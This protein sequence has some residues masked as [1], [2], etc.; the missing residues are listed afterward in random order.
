MYLNSR[1][2]TFYNDQPIRKKLVL[3]ERM[4]AILSER[5]KEF[6]NP[7]I[8]SNR[9]ES[10]RNFRRENENFYLN[11]IK[12]QE[13]RIINLE[14]QVNNKYQNSDKESYLNFLE[15]RIKELNDDLHFYY[16]K[17]IGL[18]NEVINLFQN[19]KVCGRVNAIKN[20]EFCLNRLKIVLSNETNFLT[21][22]ALRNEA[23]HNEITSLSRKIDEKQSN[24]DNM[25]ENMKLAKAKQTK[26]DENIEIN[27]K[28]LVE[29]GEDLRKD[30]FRLL[31]IINEANIDSKEIRQLENK[32][33]TYS[34]KL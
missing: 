24:L 20:F 10:L 27:V 30:I 22:V 14:S 13:E 18:Q 6:E 12:L 7:D 32:Y 15:K 28:R 9:D 23:K 29:I 8:P 25:I 5:L 16:R 21:E 2:N 3:A 33:F 4:N 11:I 34:E 26:A 31:V 19:T 17:I 1:K